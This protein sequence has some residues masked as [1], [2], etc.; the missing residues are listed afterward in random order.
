MEHVLDMSQPR[1][2]L[3]YGKLSKVTG[4]NRKPHVLTLPDCCNHA[5]IPTE[6]CYASPLPTRANTPA[7]PADERANG[8]AFNFLIG[9]R[10]TAKG[11]HPSWV[12]G[13][14]VPKGLRYGSTERHGLF[15]PPSHG[16]S[17]CVSEIFITH[18]Q[19]SEHTIRFV[20]LIERIISRKSVSLRYRFAFFVR[21][22]MTL[23]AS[24]DRTLSLIL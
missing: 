6:N 21:S 3:V 4:S 8:R 9:I 10:E 2:C 23:L 1:T 20:L 5:I 11:T 15:S 7:L 17:A 16:G 18:F 22:R 12:K 13:G 24:N 19:H 14:R